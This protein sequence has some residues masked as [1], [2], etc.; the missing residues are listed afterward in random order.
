M[1][2]VKV[3][4]KAVAWVAMKAASSAVHWAEQRVASRADQT[5]YMSVELTAS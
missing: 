1:A 2:G 5:V 4:Q 3:C